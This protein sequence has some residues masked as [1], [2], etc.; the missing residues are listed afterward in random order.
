MKIDV[1]VFKF[2]TIAHALSKIV[3]EL[4]EKVRR[5]ELELP[6]FF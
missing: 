5:I 1:I 3:V 6:L 4:A 2:L